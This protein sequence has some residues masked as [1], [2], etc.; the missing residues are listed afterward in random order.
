LPFPLSSAIRADWV[1][2]YALFTTA[3]KCTRS[4]HSQAQRKIREETLQSAVFR[5][6]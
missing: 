5:K 4:Q 1:R 6:N 2:M 3:L